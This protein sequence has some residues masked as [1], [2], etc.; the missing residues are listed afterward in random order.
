[1]ADLVPFYRI[2]DCC[3]VDGNFVDVFININTITPWQDGIYS[4]PFI[5]GDLVINSSF[6]LEADKTYLII[7]GSAPTAASLPTIDQIEINLEEAA[8]PAGFDDCS[9]ASVEI[10]CAF[11]YFIEPMVV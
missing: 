9:Q 2:T 8:P 6:T 11:L 1:M 4:R 5:L 10:P 7:E 3:S